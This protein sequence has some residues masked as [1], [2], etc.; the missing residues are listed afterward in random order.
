MY[1][2]EEFK[3]DKKN[4][5]DASK[6]VFGFECIG[7]KSVYLDVENVLLAMKIIEFLGYSSYNLKINNLG[8]DNGRR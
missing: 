7:D 1:L 2:N 8:E 3:Y 4:P 5:S 6:Y